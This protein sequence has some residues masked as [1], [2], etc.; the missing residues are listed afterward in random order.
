MFSAAMVC[1]SGPQRIIELCLFQ[2]LRKGD[3][4]KGG[5]CRVQC[6]AEGNK[7]YS[8]DIGPSST[9]GIQSATATR[10][11]IFLFTK[12]PFKNPLFLYS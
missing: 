10:E 1:G 8:R 6:H 3:F 9:F 7:K 12:T 4:S 5:F 11:C 2:E